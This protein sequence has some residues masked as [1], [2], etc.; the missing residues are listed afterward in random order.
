MGAYTEHV[1]PR[2]VDVACNVKQAQAQRRRL[3]E[4]LFGEVVEIG[5]GSGLNVPHYPAAVTA[6]AAVEPADVGW[7]L[8]AKRLRES[9][10]PVRRA[11]L[12]GQALPFEDDRFDAAVS[13]WTMCTIPDVDAAL[14]ELRRVLK[15]GGT[16]HFVEHGLAPDE[17]VRR[18]QHRLEPLQKRLFG[19]CHLTRPVADLIRGAGFTI[20][21]LD[22][23]YEKGSPKVVGANSLGVARSD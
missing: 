21:Q 8:A 18:W 19:G 3:C 6:V 17:A 20:T 15:P 2:I 7:K 13:A 11:G 12:D 16:L 1:L 14:R 9:T 22:T 23:Y 5:F 4:G 10:I